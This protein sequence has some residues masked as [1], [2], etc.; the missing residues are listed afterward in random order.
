MTWL[1]AATFASHLRGRTVCHPQPHSCACDL[2]DDGRCDMRDWLKFG[3]DWGRTDCP[4][5]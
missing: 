2:N 5:P 1:S 3:E 4:L